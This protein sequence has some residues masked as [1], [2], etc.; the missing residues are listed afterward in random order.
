MPA[1]V[2]LKVGKRGEKG[3]VD[4]RC[5]PTALNNVKASNYLLSL[6]I[7][8]HLQH[9]RISVSM[10]RSTVD[11]IAEVGLTHDEYGDVSHGAKVH[12]IVQFAFN[13][14]LVNDS[15][16]EPLDES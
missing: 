5:S 12:E 9:S 15:V 13:E 8:V 3:M 7:F 1:Q 14:S 11:V 4:I 16:E 6:E 2:G 10:H